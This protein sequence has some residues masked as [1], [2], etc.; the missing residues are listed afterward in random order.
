MAWMVR[1]ELEA[2][3]TNSAALFSTNV[4]Q[5]QWFWRAVERSNGPGTVLSFGD[6]MADP[7]RSI[8]QELFGRLQ[9]KLGKSGYSLLA[10]WRDFSG[11]AGLAN[12][13]TNW[14]AFHGSLPPGGSF[15]F[16]EWEWLPCDQVG[17][18]WVAQ[19]CGGDFTVRLSTNF[20][21]WS[22]PLM[23]LDGYAATPVGRYTNFPVARQPFYR[24]RLDGL[25]GTN[26]IVGPE[27]TDRASNGV[28]VA[29]MSRGGANLN[30]VLSISTNVL[31]PILAGLNPQLA[32]FH[33]KELADIGELEFS[34]RLVE[35]EVMWRACVTEGDVAYLG[36]PYDI[37]DSL[38]EHTGREN[39]V[40]R[41]AA[42]RDQRTYL[43]CMT[44]CVSYAAMT[45]NGYLG[46]DGIH[47]SDACDK[48]LVDVIWPQLGFF[49]LRMDRRLNVE[50]ANGEI[51]IQWPTATNVIYQVE[52]SL[53]LIT[54]TA[55][56]TNCGNGT[57]ASWT[58]PP[59]QSGSFFRTRLTLP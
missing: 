30:Q 31:Y 21:G 50:A 15:H 34:N 59:G 58:N 11:G 2:Q 24:L 45:N 27:F 17:L 42:V 43:D 12:P 55:V 29:Y 51:V 41:Q 32:V 10:W 16:D 25:G 37:R 53:D 6:S 4:S 57:A 49:A 35:L 28:H 26:A 36:T 22:A 19:P 39:L 54:W 18:Y 44:P 23:T 52:R 48:F 9:D 7:S 20:Q 46:P 1:L 8:Q 47:P 14:W 5:I 33:M 56:H 40:L 38:G 13:D 3:S